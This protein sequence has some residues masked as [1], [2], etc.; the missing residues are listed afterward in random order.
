MLA[1]DPIKTANTY[2]SSCARLCLAIRMSSH[3][4]LDVM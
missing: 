4:L 2:V 3:L 1:R